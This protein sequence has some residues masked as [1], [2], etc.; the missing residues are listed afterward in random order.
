[1]KG[2]IRS[3]G[4]MLLG[5]LIGVLLTGGMTASQPQQASQGRLFFI[6]AGLHNRTSSLTFIRDNKTGSCWLGIE[7]VKGQGIT[8][9]ADAP[10]ASCQQ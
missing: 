4:L 1:M 6:D 2:I 5:V 8:S 10:N 9:V 3:I 7:R